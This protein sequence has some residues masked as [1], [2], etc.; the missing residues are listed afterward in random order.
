MGTMLT[1]TGSGAVALVLVMSFVAHLVRPAVL[2]G[3]LRAHG[4]LPRSLVAP[5]AV[6][7][8][9]CEGAG[10]AITGFGLVTAHATEV[11]AGS[12]VCVALLAAYALYARHVARLPRRVPCGCDASGTPMTAWVAIRATGLAVLAVTGVAHPALTGL[13]GP[14]IA[15]AALAAT[16]FAVTAW[17]LPTALVDP[18]TTTA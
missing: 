8:L 11:R 4:V 15:V 12:I 18:A 17:V 2:P 6:A 16:A 13:G 10:G 9:L 1:A 14:D 5:T 7:A 3:A